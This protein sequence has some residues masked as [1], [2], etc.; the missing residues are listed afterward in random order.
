MLAVRLHATGEP[1]RVE[2]LPLPEPSGTEVRIRV[3]GCGVCR[4]DLHVVDGVQARVELPRTLG[5]EIAGRVD[6]VGPAAGPH[7]R[8]ARLSNGDP[9]VVHGGWGC[10]QC[11]ECHVGA[12]QR[13]D[14]SVAPGFQ[15]DGGYAEAMVVPHPRYLQAL[16]SL[17]PAHAAPL[18]DAGITAHRAVARAQRWLVPGARVAVIGAGGVGQFVLQLLRRTRTG[19][20]LVVAVRELDPARLERAVELGADIGILDGDASMMREALGGPADVVIDVVGTDGTLGHAAAT[21]APDGL[22]VLVGEAG[23]TLPFGF[24]RLPVESWV[25]TVAWGTRAD[26]EAVV[27]L[28][29]RGQLRW[30]TEPIPLRDAAVAHARL[31]AGE[32]AGRLVLVP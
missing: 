30:E 12:E 25:T 13:C 24:D 16:G 3:A 20:E 21:V 23:G 19:S 31:R 5:H 6:A 8:R 7:L 10:G 22:V 2:E 11:R 9:V 32:V 1:L 4:T 15:A 26:L 14:R 18:A 28:A 27:R 17:D 29:R